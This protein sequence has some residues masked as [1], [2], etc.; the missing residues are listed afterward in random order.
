VE[1]LRRWTDSGGTWQVVH[2]GGAGV[3]VLLLTCDGGEEM[4]RIVSS[5]PA[6]L[7][8]LGDRSWSGD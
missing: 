2:R 6:L 5:D 8:Y 1:R 7:G 4:G 3:E